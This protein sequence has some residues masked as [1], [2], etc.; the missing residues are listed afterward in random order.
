VAVAGLALSRL[1]HHAKWRQVALGARFLAWAGRWACGAPAA[2]PAQHTRQRAH[3]HTGAA[4]NRATS[5]D[6]LV[7]P[8]E[9]RYINRLAE[10]RQG[11]G[12]LDRMGQPRPRP[13]AARH[14]PRAAAR[15]QGPP[16]TGRREEATTIQE[17]NAQ[18]HAEAEN[19]ARVNEEIERGR[20]I[21]RLDPGCRSL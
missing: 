14:R 21:P 16:Q 1:V 10:R 6:R 11:S 7:L 12:V 13:P 9:R 19:Q 20:S 15:Q 18:L 5:R 17:T 8:A 3:A 2:R 4:K